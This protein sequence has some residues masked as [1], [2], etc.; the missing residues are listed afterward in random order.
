MRDIGGTIGDGSAGHSGLVALAL[1][2]VERLAARR[3]D[4]V[5]VLQ[6]ALL[7]RI[8]DLATSPGQGAAP[9]MLAAFRDAR[10]PAEQIADHYLPGAAHAFGEAWLEDRL[11]FSEVTM[12]VARLQEVLRHLENDG[13][14]DAPAPAGVGAALVLV[15]PGEQHTLGALLLTLGL[16]RR[17]VSVNLQFAPAMPDLSRLL[18]ERPVAVAFVS[19]GSTERLETCVNLVKTLKR[20]SRGRMRVAVG[21]AAIE[22]CREALV[23]SGADLV[24]ND[25]DRVLADAARHAGPGALTAE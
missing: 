13:W 10:I 6:P 15:P 11:T 24:T 19:L 14:I 7:D 22:S 5:G 16:R 8:V 18:A 2:A 12:G 20:L 17:G 25:V 21:G 9:A 1:Q 23:I 4:G 3:L